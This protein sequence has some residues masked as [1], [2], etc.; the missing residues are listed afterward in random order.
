[1]KTP[2]R[3]DWYLDGAMREIAGNAEKGMRAAASQAQAEVVVKLSQPGSGRVY[4]KHQASA[5]GEPPAPDTGQLRQSVFSEVL[6]DGN[7]VVGRVVENKE[8]AA[9]LE[10]GTD[11]IAPRPHVRV[12]IIEGFERIMRA[13]GKNF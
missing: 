8:Y 12:A 2:V 6:R 10:T 9:P 3:Y 1:M 4:G 7:D 11:K 13:F 5:P